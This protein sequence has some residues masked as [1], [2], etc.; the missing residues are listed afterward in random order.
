MIER[1]TR[2]AMAALWSADARYRLWLEIETRALESMVRYG[3]VPGEAARA[4]L[5]QGGFDPV[6]VAELEQTCRH[7]VIAFLTNVAES[8]GPDG[9][10]LHQG[11]TSSDLL[12]TAFAIQLQR[13]IGILLEDIDQLL[14]LL[15]RRIEDHRNTCCL[16]RTHG[17]GAELTTF[18][19]KLAGHYAEFLRS[20][21]RLRQARDDVGFCKLSG[22]VGTYATID[23]RVE[24]EVA[25]H[26]GLQIEPV[27]TQVV[28]RDRHAACFATL[29][30]VAA[31]VERLAV[32]IRHLQRSEV[33]E[34]CEPLSP[35]QKGSSAMPHKRNPLLCENLTG[36]SRL[37]R[38]TVTPAFENI[39]LWHERDISHSSVERVIAPQATSMLDFALTRL[40]EIIS[41]L[42][43]DPAAMRANLDRVGGQIFSQPVLLAL[44]QAGMSREQAYQ[45]VQEISARARAGEGNFED[46]LDADPDLTACLPPE[47]IRDLFSIKA[48]LRHVEM[49]ID[50]VLA[51]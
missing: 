21:D 10:Y 45:R 13:A 30:L 17:V 12:D 29:A 20:R 35:G 24:Q 48:Q 8:M 37:V 3:M 6:R 14:Q 15:R 47:R 23:P 22:A 11:M 51:Q 2:P 32:E 38:S 4:L 36:L 9:R 26:F 50:R 16:G 19:L 1:Y 7:E 49:I 33:A 42:E 44:T 43:V 46:L 27:A 31:A 39:V 34:V 18:G 5:C 40:T 41:G 28:P 25:G